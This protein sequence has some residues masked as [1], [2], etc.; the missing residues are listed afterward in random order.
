MHYEQVYCSQKCA[1]GV[2]RMEDIIL[3]AGRHLVKSRIYATFLESPESRDSGPREHWDNDRSSIAQDFRVRRSSQRTVRDWR[4]FEARP[5]WRGSPRESVCI[6]SWLS[7]R[8]RP[9]L[10]V[11]ASRH[12]STGRGS[13]RTFRSRNYIYGRY[14]N[15]SALSAINDGQGYTGTWSFKRTNTK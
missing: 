6:R 10:H 8:L 11:R 7:R 14:T 4:A 9:G 5:E 15:C 13:W 12:G 2:K 1:S 3:I